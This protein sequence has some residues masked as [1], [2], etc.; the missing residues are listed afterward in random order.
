MKTAMFVAL[1]LGAITYWTWRSFKLLF[2][3]SSFWIEKV[4]Y[5]GYLDSSNI[6]LSTNVKTFCFHSRNLDLWITCLLHQMPIQY[7]SLETWS[8][9]IFP[10]V[11][12][13]V[14]SILWSLCEKFLSLL[15]SIIITSP[16]SMYVSMVFNF[17]ARI[18]TMTWSDRVWR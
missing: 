11:C 8:D 9:L 1:S 14:L 15:L 7:S 13:H 17:K 2:G 18:C 3:D 10:K 5:L 12:W 16:V 4:F 6:L